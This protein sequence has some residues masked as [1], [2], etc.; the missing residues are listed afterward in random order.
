MGRTVERLPRSNVPMSQTVESGRVANSTQQQAETPRKRLAGKQ[1]GSDQAGKNAWSE[2]FCGSVQRGVAAPV[3][4]VRVVSDGWGE[5]LPLEEV[6]STDQ[7]HACAPEGHGDRECAE[8]AVR[9]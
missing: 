1:L 4:L 5:P 8:R 9:P 2:P 3:V 6:G 7:P